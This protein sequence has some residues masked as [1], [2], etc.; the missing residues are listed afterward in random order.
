M[1]ASL[2]VRTNG[3]QTSITIKRPAG[4]KIVHCPTSERDRVIRRWIVALSNTGYAPKVY[5]YY[6]LKSDDRWVSVPGNE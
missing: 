2:I 3:N 4:L 5:Q 1:N 6:W